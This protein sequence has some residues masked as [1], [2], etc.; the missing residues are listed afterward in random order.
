[1]VH[2]IQHSPNKSQ[3]GTG[4]KSIDSLLIGSPDSTVLSSRSNTPTPETSQAQAQQ[5][6]NKYKWPEFAGFAGERYLESILQSILPMALFRTWHNLSVR[7]APGQGAYAGVARIA[8]V[9][10][11]CE[12]KIYQDLADFSERGLLEMSKAWR[13]ITTAD[14][15]QRMQ[16]VTVKNFERLYDL[17]HEFHQWS[18]DAFYIA[19][20]R[21]NAEFII[22]DADLFQKLLRFECYRKIL[23]LRKPGPKATA[24]KH[25]YNHSIDELLAVAQNVLVDNANDALEHKSDVEDEILKKQLSEQLK[26]HSV[27]G[28]IPTENFN[29]DS[30]PKT[31]T[32]EKGM[33]YP[34]TT[35]RNPTGQ[36][37]NKDQKATEQQ[38]YIETKTEGLSTVSQCGAAAAESVLGYTEKELKHDTKKRGAAAV[39]VSAEQ[40]R[41]LNGGQDRRE[42]EEARQREQ[43][44]EAQQGQPQELR[45]ERERP[46][47]VVTTI[48]AYVRQYDD[49]ELIQSDVTRALKIYFTAEEVF[50][51]FSQKL[52]WNIFSQAKEAAAKYAR[53]HTNR[54]GRTNR[55][56]YMFTCMENAFQFSLEEL[57]YMRTED[58]L[59]LEY[60]L[61]DVVDTLEATY[62]HQY[63]HR[64]TNLDYRAWLNDVLDRLEKRTKPRTRNNPTQSN[65]GRVLEV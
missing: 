4:P 46:E 47:Q 22:Q 41:K 23:L 30:F 7:E 24:R 44:R 33:T 54:Q 51:N 57:I 27:Y 3:E 35:I 15:T 11:R 45:Q 17:A 63:Q 28:S 59:Y 58:P 21:E 34:P 50:E 36:Q 55:V 61:Y 31:S 6:I 52:F 20:Q 56:P 13:P 32:S 62:Q 60:S 12:R 1:M 8:T 2:S 43:E 18:Q 5:L 29:G 26:K 14:G 39:G 37:S 25:W 48:E 64:E 53:E 49:P 38:N 40:Y 65:I 9:S 16:L 19:P 42:L 10:S